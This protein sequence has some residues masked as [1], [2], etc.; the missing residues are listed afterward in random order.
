MPREYHRKYE[1]EYYKNPINRK[2]RNALM[3]KYR[4]DPMLR[5]KHEARWRTKKAIK[6]GILKKGL[7]EICQ[8]KNTQAHHDNYNEPLKIRWLCKKHHLQIHAK[9]EGGQ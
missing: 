2:R 3:K 8:S 6:K 9:A 4:N 1:A 7:C 5:I